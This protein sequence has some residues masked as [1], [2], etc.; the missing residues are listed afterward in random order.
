MQLYTRESY[1]LAVMS[2]VAIKLQS[3]HK[4][5][6]GLLPIFTSL[7]GLLNRCILEVFTIQCLSILFIIATSVIKERHCLTI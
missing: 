1:M 5:E 4:N 3:E 7:R 2:T 6:L